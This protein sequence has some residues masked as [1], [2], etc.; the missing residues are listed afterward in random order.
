MEDLISIVLPVYNGEKYLCQSIDIR[1]TRICNPGF[2]LLHSLLRN[3]YSLAYFFQSKTL[4]F[5]EFFEKIVVEQHLFISFH[6]F[7]Y[8]VI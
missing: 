8:M 4:A 5:S 1:R 2:P 3:A 6:I 7:Y